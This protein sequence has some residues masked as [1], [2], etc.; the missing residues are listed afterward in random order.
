M[1][2]VADDHNDWRVTI[3]LASP[4][5]M[6]LAREIFAGH[7]VDGDAH[8]RLGRRVAVG[9]GGS[10]VFLYTGTEL[11]AR[12]AEQVA[13]GVLATYGLTA[14]FALHRWHPLEEDWEPAEVAMPRTDT[15]RHA[16]HR[17]LLD[18]ETARSQATGIAQWEA[19]V[20]F[21]SHRDAVAMAERLRGEGWVVVR[22]WRFLVIGADNED[23][24]R[25]L[26][27][28]LRRE[29]PPDAAVSAEQS[30]VYLPFIPF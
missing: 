9:S 24:A 11:A 12:E 29:A 23:Q 4:A 16:E 6:K 17:K 3:S 10:Q 8:Q 25:D 18:E 5:D 15:E 30:G 1:P 27:A 2:D 19:R 26:A 20:E 28:R 22:R 13:R 14:G 7:Q 21:S